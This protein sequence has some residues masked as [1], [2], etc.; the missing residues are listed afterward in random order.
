MS[1]QDLPLSTSARRTKV[2][3]ATGLFWAIKILSTG[4]GET[5][6]DYLVGRF[7]PQLAVMAGGIGLLIA[8]AVQI[9]TPRYR[10]WVYWCAVV[11][12]GV[13]GTMAVDVIHVFLGVPLTVSTAFFA[14]ALGVI[15]WMWHR[16]EGT[17]SIHSIRTRP[18]EVFYWLAVMATFALGTAAGDLTAHTLGMGFLLSGILFAALFV[19]PALAYWKFGLAEVPAFWCA[20]V[21][22]RPLGASFADWM[23]AP[24]PRGG[25]GWGMGPVSLALGALIV[26][27]VAVEARHSRA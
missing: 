2:P 25:L 22:T 9:A 23:G 27:L 26:V 18:R 14:A 21:L 7:N 6:S 20:Y 15:F 12:V 3:D 10:P 13:F 1:I 8:L 5:T 19:L 17:L 24:L 11:M 4:M 16:R